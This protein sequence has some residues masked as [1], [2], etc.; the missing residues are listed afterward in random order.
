MK[1]S[2]L[3]FSTALFCGGLTANANSGTLNTPATGIG[4]G[5]AIV[6]AGKTAAQK[7]SSQAVIVRAKGAKSAAACTDPVITPG[8]SG[9]TICAGQSVSLTAA[10]ADVGGA[11]NMLHFESSRNNYVELP[12]SLHKSMNA[13]FTFE[14]FVRM[15]SPVDGYANIFTF[16]SS[17]FPSGTND[18][19]IAL[20]IDGNGQFTIDAYNRTTNIASMLNNFFTYPAIIGT[21]MTHLAVTMDGTNISIFINGNA[22]P[23]YTGAYGVLPGNMY[24][25]A[26]GR[27]GWNS[28]GR[29]MYD[30][31][32]PLPTF[33]GDMDEVRFWNVAR[34]GAEIHD[35]YNK[36]VDNDAPGLLAVYHFNEATTYIGLPVVSATG[37]YNALLSNS[38]NGGTA[39]F[40]AGTDQPYVASLI[41]PYNQTAYSWSAP[42]NDNFSTSSSIT[43]SPTTTTE[44]TVTAI[45]GSGCTAS[46]SQTVTVNTGS[47]PTV[48]P[49]GYLGCNPSATFTASGAG[50]WIWSNGETTQSVTLTASDTLT[51]SNGSC[52][53]VPVFVTIL[54]PD[55][56]VPVITSTNPSS[57]I[58]AG[59]AVTFGALSTTTGTVSG[60]NML[61]FAS[62]ANGANYVR[63]PN[64][65]HRSMQYLTF[66]AYVRITNP[67][68]SYAPIFS[69]GTD[70][71]VGSYLSL[72]VHA[73]GNMSFLAYNR[74]TNVTYTRNNF[75]TAG[76]SFTMNTMHH[77]AF[78]LDGVWGKLYL[79]GNAACVDSFPCTL[80]PALLG[81]GTGNSNWNMLGH[82]IYADATPE[83]NFKGFMDEVRV[84]NVSRTGAQ[85]AA[86][87][88][89][90]LAAGTPGLLAYY[91]MDE[92]VDY[93]GSTL[94][95][96]SGSNNNATLSTTYR[97]GTPLPW[98]ASGI[99]GL[100]SVSYKWS[101]PGNPDF[102][103][104]DTVSVRPSVTTTYTVVASSGTG[105]AS[106][107][108]VT[109]TVVPAPS[110]ITQPSSVISCSGTNVFI[111]VD[112]T[113]LG[114]DNYTWQS[115]PD[116][117]NWTNVTASA[118]YSNVTSDTLRLTAPGADLNE[119]KYRV[120]IP[121]GC[122]LVD[123]SNS[124][125]LTIETVGTPSVTVAHTRGDTVCPGAN[126]VFT[127]TPVSGGLNPTYVWKVNGNVVT[128]AA[129]TYT[130]NTLRTADVV[131]V[132]L[133][134]SSPCATVP[135]ASA[136]ARSI[137]IP[138]TGDL[139]ASVVISSSVSHPCPGTVSFTATATNGGPAP[140]YFWRVN[141][142]NSG[143]NS[144]VFS[145]AGLNPGDVV[146]VF[147]SSNF[148]CATPNIAQSNTITLC[149]YADYLWENYRD[150]R[151]VSYVD[152]PGSLDEAT[153]PGPSI[154]DNQPT[155]GRYTRTTASDDRM[156]MTV[157][158]TL[159][160]LPNYLSGA[161]RF[162]MKAFSPAIGTVYSITLTDPIMA[163][164]SAFPAGRYAVFTTSSTVA[165]Q[166]ENL[167]FD[168][169]SQP[170]ATVPE[171]KVLGMEL[172]VNPGTTV[173]SVVYLDE[174]YGPVINIRVGTKSKL[175]GP[176][177]SAFPNPAT[178]VLN[179]RF[180]SMKGNA[181]VTVTDISGREMF[182]RE[183]SA[184]ETAA[185]ALNISTSGLGTGLYFCRFNSAS[186]SSVLRFNVQK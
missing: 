120:I 34:T 1:F 77:L 89:N 147:M 176:A 130:T 162:T 105:C 9:T 113:G 61:A 6:T 94:T 125:T 115:S 158:S 178:E 141:G 126:I 42:G 71:V 20:K 108:E 150:I 31:G 23:A 172:R 167:V 82:N 134:S 14:G 54:T 60:G 57:T 144:P 185:G 21:A 28:L 4:S 46:A 101:S 138:Q 66:E 65:I 22:T 146:Q 106:S 173:A 161:T 154:I 25:T 136:T 90:N 184:A 81:V 171:S 164:A 163:S 117:L 182:S 44:Y 148:A 131:T 3:L 33:K 38:A 84:W 155:V 79:D 88:R 135:T 64:N 13:G 93:A 111:G 12:D 70:G 15:A 86:N 99:A 47:I 49:P 55:I 67:V 63:M 69:L 51:V 98:V 140:D 16:G 103:S 143:E 128:G 129:N 124:A 40:L 142:Q 26:N 137:F 165:N 180:R 78:T 18:N 37:K 159:R 109:V 110:V 177:L 112:A 157:D 153:N 170:D 59:Q 56:T 122:G 72:Y 152:V 121:S 10:A 17:S 118:V 133:T 7:K 24:S 19:H 166:W 92:A 104:S 5:N 102:R 179:L 91:K 174:I 156:T 29:T 30:D 186:G 58:C 85:I 68:N 123:T 43:V 100:H 76:H 149:N 107:S 73:G 8:P 95:D 169:T 41:G 96:A 32:T 52:N 27:T 97:T 75:L 181:N 53:S 151:R 116:G 83:P 36:G 175:S 160:G 127:A 39:N 62:N 80:R 139:P 168:F 35:T 114:G 2:A 50:P 74:N 87:Y 145:T 11:G 48:D 119:Y 183:V 132:T 45:T